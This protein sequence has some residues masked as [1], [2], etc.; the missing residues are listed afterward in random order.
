[1]AQLV[2]A[3]RYRPEGRGFDSRRGNWVFF[4]YLILLPQYGPGVDSASNRNEH[5][6]YLIGSKGD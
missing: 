2:K 1:V 4:I 3:R 6:G 5:R